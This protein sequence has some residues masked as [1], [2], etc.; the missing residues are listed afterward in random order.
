[1]SKPVAT[2]PLGNAVAR[3][4]GDATKDIGVA[5][6]DATDVLL[7]KRPARLDRVEVWRVRR[8]IDDANATRATG[9]PNPRVVMSLEVVHDHDVAATKFGQQLPLH[10]RDET[11]LVRGRE[12]AGEHDPSRDPDRAEQR[13]VLA[14]V[15]RDPIDE[16]LAAL[17]PRMAPAHRH[18]HSGLVEEHEPV[19]RHATDLPQVRRTLYD[20]VRP[21]TLQRPSA[22]FF[23]T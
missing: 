19:G 8:Q 14:P 15:H 13:E 17:H 9:G 20:D 11:V 5:W 6:R 18:V 10:P 23:T 2:M 22:L 12:H 21:Q 16:F 1:M 7:L 4:T 3:T